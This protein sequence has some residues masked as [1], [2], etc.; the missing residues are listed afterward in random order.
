[1]KFDTTNLI[2]FHSIYLVHDDAKDKE[3]ELELTWISE[4]SKYMHVPVPA[5]LQK[6]AEQK[7][8]EALEN[9]D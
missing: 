3:F 4:E 2:K 6:V 1:M 7:A 5:D 9:F 8:K